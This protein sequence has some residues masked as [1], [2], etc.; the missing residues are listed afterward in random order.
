MRS[1]DH[2]VAF[3]INRSDAFDVKLRL[4]ANELCVSPCRTFDNVKVA[5]NLAVA[6]EE[7]ATKRQRLAVGVIHNQENSRTERFLGNLLSGL[8]AG[9]T[10]CKEQE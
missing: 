8:R 2:Q 5:R 1:Y 10:R 7:A 3:R 4:L 6:D 9:R